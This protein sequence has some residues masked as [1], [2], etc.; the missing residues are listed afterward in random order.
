[1]PKPKLPFPKRRMLVEEP[2][3]RALLLD[4]WHMNFSMGFQGGQRKCSFPSSYVTLTRTLGDSSCGPSTSSLPAAPSSIPF[5]FSV[6]LSVL[7]QKLVS[8][9]SFIVFLTSWLSSISFKYSL[10]C[11]L[12]YF[13]GLEQK[14]FSHW[15]LMVSLTSWLSQKNSVWNYI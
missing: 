6:S 12:F 2:I 10:F 9:W 4:A 11:C 5:E 13:Y 8:V 3:S 14:P 7:G 15:S 1:M